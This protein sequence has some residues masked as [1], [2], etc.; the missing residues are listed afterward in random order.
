M[1]EI[2]FRAWDK[3]NY[4]MI[5]DIIVI[6]NREGYLAPSVKSVCTSRIISYMQYTGLKDKNGKEI[7]E[8]DIVKQLWNDHVGEVR[9]NED[10][11]R[12]Y[13]DESEDHNALLYSYDT[14]IIGNT[15]ENPE[16]LEKKIIKGGRYECCRQDA[17]KAV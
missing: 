7:Y 1:R 14:E 15:Y 5:Y 4:R 6:E 17:R 13:I 12:Y 11:A 16:L 8:G 3:L 2:K 9:Y 10:A